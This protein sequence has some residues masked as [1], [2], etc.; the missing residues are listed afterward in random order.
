MHHSVVY[1]A[2]GFMLPSVPEDGSGY[3]PCS[4]FTRNLHAG[5]TTI[6]SHNEASSCTTT[7]VNHPCAFSVTSLLDWL[8]QLFMRKKCQ[9]FWY[10]IDSTAL[11]SQV[12]RMD[13]WMKA[14]GHKTPKRS[15]MWS[16]TKAV[17]KFA[18]PK[19][20][21]SGKYSKLVRRYE[22]S[23]GRKRFSGNKKAL[24]ASATLECI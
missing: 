13:F 6:E 10:T 19:L 11:P 23:D 4:W 12:W 1:M 20:K 9:S 18:T 8:F 5:A 24:K 21:M 16:N 14:Y 3:I 17:K 22:N 15:S 7:I 2:Y